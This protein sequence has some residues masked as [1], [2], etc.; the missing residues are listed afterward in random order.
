MVIEPGTQ[1]LSCR[2]GY[3]AVVLDARRV[4]V[5][6][7]RS[8]NSTFLGTTE[9]LDTVTI[10]FA[11]GLSTQTERFGCAAVLPP[12]KRRV[13]VVGG[14]DGA[15]H[16]AMTEILDIDTMIF[17]PGPV[18]S[19]GRALPGSIL[20]IGGITYDDD[21]G[22]ED[23]Y[24]DDDDGDDDDDDET[25]TTEALTLQAMSF[26]AG[27]TMLTAL[28]RCATFALTQEH[29]PRRTLVVGGRGATYRLASR[30]P[31]RRCLRLWVERR[32]SQRYKPCTAGALE[33]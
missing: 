21:V 28:S 18:M 19:L 12:E 27:P 25:N 2:Y 24:D 20:M 13:L 14:N 5:I 32:T 11:P 1:M 15:T 31:R 17:S 22:D 10:T 3:A 23:E 6:G 26:A 30:G 4:L 33:Q 9:V 29:S 16:L 7:G 8:D